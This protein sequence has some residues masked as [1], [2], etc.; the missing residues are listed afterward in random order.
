MA[1]STASS[2]GASS[3]RSGTR[4]GIPACWILLFARTSRCAIAAGETRK[5]EPI[6][7]ASKPSVVCRINGARTF[8]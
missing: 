1:S 4:K 7:A 8:A 2:R 6:V 5:A 3:E